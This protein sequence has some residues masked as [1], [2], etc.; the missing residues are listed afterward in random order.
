[1]RT[2]ISS[3][4][5]ADTKPHYHILDGLR[6]VAAFVVVAY[7]IFEAFATSSVDQIVN[8]GYMAV[9]FFFILSGFVIGYSYDGRAKTVSAGS[10]LKRRLIRLQPMVLFGAL[11]GAALFYWQD[12][13]EWQVHLVSAGAL[14][15]ATLMSALL[16]PATPTT[17]IRGLGEMYPLNGPCWSL[18]FEYIGYLL[19]A[20]ILRRLTTRVLG[21]LTLLAAATFC[22]FA[23]AYND[24]YIGMGWTL[25][26]DNV[27]GGSL[28][29]L[30]SFTAG[31]FLSRIFKPCRTKHSFLLGCLLLV[32]LCAM[33]HVGGAQE[34]WLNGVY[35]M[36]CVV[37]VFPAIVYLG[38]SDAT[39]NPRILRLAQLLGDLSYP[40][41]I[42]HYPLIY[43]YYAWVKNNGLTFAESLLGAAGVVVGSIVV[44]Y[45]ALKCYDEPLRRWL[46]KKF[47]R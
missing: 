26:P 11:F 16:I 42:V 14:L 17:E 12:Y 25:T 39:Q 13:S 28:R 27:L 8:H 35:T 18:F 23:I 15:V 36:V 7:H 40:L 2:E 38:A 5:F 1:M 41:Y 45:L 9:D 44:A 31:L 6:G 43:L 32:V 30:F 10:F 46:S 22:W 20:F 21:L 29:L 4:A 34:T 47:I 37:G 3:A 19:Y 24:G 33:P